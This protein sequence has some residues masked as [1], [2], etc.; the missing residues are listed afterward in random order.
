MRKRLAP[1]RPDL[2]ARNVAEMVSPV[3]LGDDHSDDTSWTARL[4]SGDTRIS[5]LGAV[6]S[7]GTSRAAKRACA[8]ADELDQRRQRK[9]ASCPNGATDRAQPLTSGGQ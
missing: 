3:A 6:P 8:D 5:R 1:M 2:Q 7:A 9:S 4:A